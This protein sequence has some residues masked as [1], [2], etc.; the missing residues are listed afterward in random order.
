MSSGI[1]IDPLFVP[2][3]I[4]L[5][6][7][8][9]PDQSEKRRPILVISKFSDKALMPSSRILVCLAITSNPNSDKFMIPISNDS[10]EERQFPKPSKVVCDNFFTILK[11]DVIKR[12]GKV[13]PEFYNKICNLIKSDVLDIN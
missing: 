5:A 6:K 1:P 10:M 13:T 3:E 7:I 12:I 9:F 11:S 4:L 2:R 8:I